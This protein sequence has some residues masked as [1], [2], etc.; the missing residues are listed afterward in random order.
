M[1][2]AVSATL[3]S[4]TGSSPDG[5][6]PRPVH[7]W[8]D[9]RV[10][11]RQ[12]GARQHASG[13]A[14]G[15]PRPR[16]LPSIDHSSLRAGEAGEGDIHVVRRAAHQPDGKLRDRAPG[17]H[18]G[19]RG[20]AR[21]RGI[22]WLTLIGSPVSGSGIRQTSAAACCRSNT[23]A[24]A[25]RGAGERRMRCRIG[26]P[27]VAQPDLAVVLQAAEELLARAC[28]QPAIPSPRPSSTKQDTLM[29][30]Q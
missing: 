8:M 28:R 9:D 7:R 26:H 5:T 14:P 29:K 10:G 19:A 4:C 25:V 22:M 16:S 12:I 15:C 30:N 11:Q 20:P 23:A 24:I 18:A 13:S 6:G 17:R 1:P 2:C 21:D 27:L 3:C